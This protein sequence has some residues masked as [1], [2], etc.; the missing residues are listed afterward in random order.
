[1]TTKE[2]LSPSVPEK[3]PTEWLATLN[4]TEWWQLV[5]LALGIGFWA[6][7]RKELDAY[8]RDNKKTG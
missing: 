5:D 6:N 4:W 8:I 1:M 3:M 7:K 2:T